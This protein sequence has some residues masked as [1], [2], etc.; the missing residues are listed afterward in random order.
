MYLNKSQRQINPAK[1]QNQPRTKWVILGL[2]MLTNTL[3]AAVPSMCLPVLFDQI[4]TDLS[5]NLVQVGFIWGIGALPGI[6]TALVGGSIGDRLGP[7]RV[8]IASC[9]LIGLT[10]ALRGMA[11]N[12]T[13]LAAAVFLFGVFSPYITMNTIKTCG[14]WFP[15]NQMGLASGVLSMGMAFGFLSSSM[16]SATVL[17]PWL[18]G[19]RQVLFLYGGI[20]AAFS[21]PWF[22]SKQA[23]V[24]VSR[25]SPPGNT[26]SLLGNLSHVVRIR[27]VWMYGLVIL[28]IGGCVQ[29]TLGYLA[30]YLRGLGWADTH[31]DGALAAFHS[32]SML[33]V[34][35]IAL[36]SDKLGSRRKVLVV[37]GMMI[38]A[39]VGLL[40][41]AQGALIW[42]VVCMAGMVRDG[43][44]A[45]FTTAVMEIDGIGTTY[46]G[47]AMGLVMIFAG[48]GSLLAPPLGNS[49][50]SYGAG[51]PFLFWAAL[52]LVG[53]AGLLGSRSK[54]NKVFMGRA[55]LAQ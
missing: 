45:V 24:P 26:D 38:T 35:P 34:I 27:A 8:L 36:L 42:V 1:L 2:A 48:L 18:G 49:L 7:R 23:V 20:A 43:F 4:S 40:S 21:I 12:F 30:L 51:F 33:C 55:K 3:V 29:G 5:L 52:T 14:M 37:A 28:G 47:T 32:I 15:R 6:F 13:T 10:G 41:I 25:E 16:L 54:T 46:T 39:G 44:M 19:W 11:T 9:L 17:S 31:A 22:F 53:Y 50:A